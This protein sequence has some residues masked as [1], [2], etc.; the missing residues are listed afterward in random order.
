MRILL[1]L[2]HS[3]EERDQL[4]LLSSLGYEVASLGGYIDPANPH[5]PKRPPLGGVPCHA[6]VKNAVDAIGSD[7]NLGCAQSCIPD[8]VLEWLG[9]DGIIIYHHYLDRLYGQWDRV[10]D[11][12]RGGSGRRVVWRTVGQSVQN[13]EL[14]AAPYRRDRLEIVR[15]SPKERNIPDYAGEDALIRFWKDEEEWSGWVGD[16]PT[17]I[18]VTQ[19]LA[20]REPYTNFGFWRAVTE[21]R[22]LLPAVA[23]GPGSGSIGG[24]GELGYDVMRGWLRRARCYLYTGTQPAS[25]TLG[26]VEAMMTGI[27][28]VSIGPR[29][30]GVFPY[31]PEL[32]EGHEIAGRWTN[33]PDVAYALLRELLDDDDLA[34]EESVRQRAVACDLF[35]RSAAA[36]GWASF[37]G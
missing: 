3:I 2:S 34:A 29:W 1:C 30:M 32:F 18:N 17:V 21:G 33:S 6:E 7:D 28:V 27:P 20:Q 5:D 24:P 13:N 10:R 36:A 25:Y 22:P 16:L 35:G 26:L 15:Y 14:Q 9:N 37:L 4:E 12:M 8:A 23:L 31:G 19:G 11:W